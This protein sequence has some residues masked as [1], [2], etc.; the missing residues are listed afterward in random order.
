M[1]VRHFTSQHEIHGWL[2]GVG[3]L[4]DREK[5]AVEEEFMKYNHRG[6][7]MSK[8]EMQYKL[9]RE[10]RAMRD[11]GTIGNSDYAALE[12]GLLEMYQE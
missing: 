5:A 1:S 9:L 11:H 12:A 6:E 7:G 10:L 3:S 2:R 4:D 8:D